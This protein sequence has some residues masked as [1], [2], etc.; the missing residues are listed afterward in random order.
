MGGKDVL[1]VRNGFVVRAGG[2]W[3]EHGIWLGVGDLMMC[4][5]SA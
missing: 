5:L 4:G 1:E 2:L 3:F